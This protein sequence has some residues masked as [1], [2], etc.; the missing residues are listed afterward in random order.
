MT[1]STEQLRDAMREKLNELNTRVEQA[2]TDIE[3]ANLKQQADVHAKLEQ[4]RM[5]LQEKQQDATHARTKLEGD[6]KAKKAEWQEKVQ[7]WKAQRDKERLE[8]RAEDAEHFASAAFD[9]AVAAV[10]EADVAILEAI[11][12]KQEADAA[13]SI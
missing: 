8:A 9:V 13:T 12:A 11:E 7:D 3:Q 6:F 2:K 5:K 1:T 4:A 10:Y